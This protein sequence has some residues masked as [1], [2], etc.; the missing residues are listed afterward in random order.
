MARFP[1]NFKFDSEARQKVLKGMSIVNKVVSATLGPQ[2]RNVAINQAEGIPFIIHDGVTAARRVDLFDE[3]EDIGAQ[4]LKEAAINTNDKAGD[5]TTTAIILGYAILKKTVEVI[6]AG[7][8][9]MTLKRQIEEANIL[10]VKG[11]KKLAKEINTYSETEQIAAIS[12]AD[13]KIGKLV[14]EA[15][16]KTGDEGTITVEEG[17]GMETTVDYKQGME[18]DRGYL[19]PYF[20][21]DQKRVEAV[22]EDA[23][24]LVTDIKMNREYEIVP[25]L[26]KFKKAEKHNLVIIGEVLEQALQTLVVN[27]LKGIIEVVAIQPPAFGGRQVDELEDIAALT[28]ATVIKKDSGRTIDSV[29]LEELGTA[30]KVV[31]DRDKTIITDGG[32]DSKAIQARIDTLQ[33]QIKVA[34]APHDAVIKEQRIAKLGGKVAIINVGGVTEVE[35]KDRKERIIDA[36][37]ATQAAIDEGVVAGGQ[38]ALLKLSVSDWWP[39]TIG[40]GILKEAIKAPFKKLMENAGHDY[41]EIWGKISPLKY[42][43]GIDVLD[44]KKKD[45]I[46]A[47]II[48]PV[49][50]VRSAL[51]NAV[52]VATMAMTM[53]VLI[54]EPYVQKETK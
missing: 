16:K 39:D 49:K 40:A 1:A 30:G 15:I 44:G 48:D 18:I 33:E 27:N 35:L 6:E 21:N 9:P 13:A 28:G 26:K 47:G 11:L 41:A 46:E 50:V 31:A 24:I 2:G 52:S 8:N 12:A 19:S 4:M 17:K 10:L 3:F 34:N 37:S 22:I 29:E 32:G 54:S 14:A 43:F 42:P 25:F 53:S 23:H 38:L 45:L 7:M 51:E 36:V 5:G 20:V